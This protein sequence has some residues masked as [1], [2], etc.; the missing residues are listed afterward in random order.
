MK[1]VTVSIER[2]VI[3]FTGVHWN[4][5]NE[6]LKRICHFYG[7]RMTVGERGSLLQREASAS[8][9]RLLQ[10]IRQETFY[11]P[12]KQRLRLSRPT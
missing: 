10:G 7:V 3:D 12:S 8:G 6:F 11:I 2:I 5:F 1:G 4:F 9:G